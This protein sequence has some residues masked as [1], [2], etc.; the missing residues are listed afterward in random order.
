MVHYQYALHIERNE[1][2]LQNKF[3]SSSFFN[4]FFFP[5]LLLTNL[6]YVH[7]SLSIFVG[8]HCSFCQQS[9]TTHRFLLELEFLNYY[10]YYYYYY[11]S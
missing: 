8:V 6:A 5:F 11:F 2:Q 9:T 4:S 7:I 10:Y 3:V 1:D